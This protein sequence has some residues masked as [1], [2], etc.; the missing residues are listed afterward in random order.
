MSHPIPADASTLIYLAKADALEEIST[1]VGSIAAAPSVW[2]EAVEAGEAIGAPEVGRIRG[3]HASGVVVRVELSRDDE[4]LADQIAT[5]HRLGRGES[6]VLALA[7]RIGRAI[8]DEGRAARVATRLGLDVVST[9]FLPVSGVEAG[10]LDRGQAI[11]L[12]RRLA[13]VTGARADVVL[14]IEQHIRSITE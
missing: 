1:F 3:A 10:M 11:A 14:M 2:R 7:T 12:L 13:V 9:L 4:A 5:Q 8:V 6:E